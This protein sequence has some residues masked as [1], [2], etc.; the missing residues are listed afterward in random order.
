MLRLS[1]SQQ[2]MSQV[3]S[4]HLHFIRAPQAHGN[5]WRRRVAC[6]HLLKLGSDSRARLPGRD[7]REGGCEPA[8]LKLST[9][10]SLNTDLKGSCAHVESLIRDSL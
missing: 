7:L 8:S 5:I 4:V 1:T 3:P 2:Y 10:F 9:A 6:G